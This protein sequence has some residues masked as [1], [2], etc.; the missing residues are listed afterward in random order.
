MRLVYYELK[1]LAGIRYMSVLLFLTAAACAGFFCLSHLTN[2]FA[3]NIDSRD[4][5]NAYSAF[6]REYNESPGRIDVAKRVYEEYLA[7]QDRAEEEFRATH[8]EPSW[9]DEEAV[10]KYNRAL[11][12]ARDAVVYENQLGYFYSDGEHI[13]DAKFFDYIRYNGRINDDWHRQIESIVNVTEGTMKRYENIGAVDAPIYG[14]QVHFNERYSKIGESVE[15]GLSYQHGWRQ[16]FDYDSSG[17]FAYVYLILAA[18]AVFLNE[19]SCG[20]LPVLRTTR[21][22]RAKTISAKTAALVITAV[23]VTVLFTIVQ[24][25]VCEVM[26]GF[27]SAG[28]PIQTIYRNCIYPW[29]IG[30]Y[31]LALLA[32]RCICA[33]AF[34]CAAGLAAA[35]SFSPVVTCAAGASILVSNV[36]VNFF[37]SGSAVLYLNLIG[38]STDTSMRQYSEVLIFGQFRST[39]LVGIILYLAI[40]AASAAVTVTVGSR[41]S[42]VSAPRRTRKLYEFLA[43][44]GD[45]FIPKRRGKGGSKLYP[46]T[47]FGWECSKLATPASIVLVILLLSAFAYDAYRTYGEAV[48]EEERAYETYLDLHL[49]G[50]LT[51]EKAEYIEKRNELIAI[52]AS[53]DSQEELL[54]AYSR[55][56]IT[57]EEYFAY[58]DGRDEAKAESLMIGRAAEDMAYLKALGSETGTRGWL[59]SRVSISRLL[60]RDV[61]IFLLAALIVIFARVYVPDFAGRSSEGSFMTIQRTT[62]RGRRA[63]FRA[64]TLSVLI[65]SFCVFVLFEAVDLLF[66][67][68]ATHRFFDILSAPVSSIEAYRSLDG[69]SIGGCIALILA[70]RFCGYLIVAYLT[71]SASYITKR[72]P[73]TL[74]ILAAFTLLPYVLVYMGALELRYID[75]T[76][77]LAGGKLLTRSADFALGG[78]V[79]T[80]ASLLVAGYSVLTLAASQYVRYKT[81][82]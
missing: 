28:D 23:F 7:E 32:T 6:V 41:R 70:L 15:L 73:P 8:E 33:A 18:G 10:R 54:A 46:K 30:G 42:F 77:M 80:F 48:S 49:F 52:L 60:G 34:A 74:F 14:Y 13:P 51:D 2:E 21:G 65:L 59:F 68:A 39:R 81:G 9:S 66:G 72:T 82:R 29:T 64:R 67:I 44:I 1:K 69:I 62:R 63:S 3:D 36:I 5:A 27:S 43:R 76:A 25:A 58:L 22:G 24:L 47:L 4:I 78:G 38:M 57:A 50:E 26:I 19:R 45:K 55:G 71:V 79:Y 61:N 37:T 53:D 35:L 20:F 11:E 75:F 56:D 12:A 40:A 31:A 17:I 16:F